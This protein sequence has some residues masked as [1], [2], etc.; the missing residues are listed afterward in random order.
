[1]H[2]LGACMHEIVR[3]VIAGGTIY[4]WERTPG[5]GK[6]VSYTE[7]PYDAKLMVQRQCSNINVATAKLFSR[8][9]KLFSTRC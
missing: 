5:L 4:A 1:M 8:I 3:C 2:S 9:A 7:Y 6:C